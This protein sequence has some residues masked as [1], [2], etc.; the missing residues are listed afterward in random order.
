MTVAVSLDLSIRESPM[1]DDILNQ[2]INQYTGSISN[3]QTG[4]AG[5]GLGLFN[6]IAA[7]SIALLALNHLLRKNVDMVD[8][9]MELI[10]WL[11]YLNFFYYFIVNY[12][13]IY[14]LYFDTVD[15]IGN[16]LGAQASGLPSVTDIQ[17]PESFPYRVSC[18]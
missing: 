9:N 1:N 16:L 17:R 3:I 6:T 13:S 14:G 8:A 2:V 7:I 15:Q 10:K 11:I 18:G 4:S 12:N 5:I